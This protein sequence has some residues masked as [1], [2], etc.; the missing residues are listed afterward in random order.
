MAIKYAVYPG[1]VESK[2]DGQIRYIGAYQ[3]IQFYRVDPSECIVIRPGDRRDT[4]G[5]I[6]LDPSYH[7]DYRLPSRL[8]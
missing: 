5:L 1:C 4:T 8:P 3:L 7:G 6:R 2:A